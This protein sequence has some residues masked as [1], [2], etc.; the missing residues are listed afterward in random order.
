MKLFDQALEL[1][2]LKNICEGTDKV[3][4][5]LLGTVNNSYFYTSIAQETFNRIKVIARERSTIPTWSDLCTDPILSENTREILRNFD[6]SLVGNVKDGN[7]LVKN[8]NNFRKCRILHSIAERIQTEIIKDSIDIDKIYGEVNEDIASA[9]SGQDISECFTHIGLHSNTKDKL[10]E[11][12]MGSAQRYILTGFNG[13]DNE[14]GG[15]P[16]GKLG[17]IAATTGSGKSLCA[18]QLAINMAKNGAKVC[19]V[20]LEMSASDMLQRF[21]ANTSDLTMSQ[22]TKAQELTKKQREDAWKTFRE[23]EKRIATMGISIDLFNP[24]EDIT[25]ESLLFLLKPFEYECIIIDYIGLLKG[26]EGDDQWRK[27]GDAVRFA[28]RWAEATGTSVIVLAQLKED[29][30]IKASKAMKDHADLM[31]TWHSGKLSDNT[32]GKA[33]VRI[34]PQKG[35]NQAQTGFLLTIDFKNM[36]MRDATKE[37]EEAWNEKHNKNETPKTKTA[38]AMKSGEIDIDYSEL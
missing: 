37:E 5:T 1:E 10:Y 3:S 23:L 34:E 21:L 11:I 38:A 24:R 25:M 32:E 27:M 15:I 17:I 14:N 35:R 20:P 36:T 2:V 31:W 18:N 19:I 9:N 13:W 12:L 28:K 29:M 16:R 6:T 7:E 33:T 26:F 22:L 30:V 8:L 4:S